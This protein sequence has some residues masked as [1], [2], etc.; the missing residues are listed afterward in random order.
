MKPIKLLL[1]TILFSCQGQV[2]IDVIGC[3]TQSI[4]EENTEERVYRP[5][6]YK[7]FSTE[8]FRMVFDL[9]DDHTCEYK[10]LSPSDAHFMTSGIWLFES[11]V[12]TIYDY[13]GEIQLEGIVKKLSS[14]RLVLAPID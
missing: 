9:F 12:L 4:E 13:D 6:D 1:I 8:R 7:E 10:V 2:E 5:C 14:N 11:D 3:W